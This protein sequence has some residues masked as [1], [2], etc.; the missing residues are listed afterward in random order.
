[1]SEESEYASCRNRFYWMPGVVSLGEKNLVLTDN[2]Y[3]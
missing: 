2:V 1:M 3:I